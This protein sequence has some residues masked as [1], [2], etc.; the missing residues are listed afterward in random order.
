MIIIYLSFRCPSSQAILQEH[1]G[2]LTLHLLTFHNV[3][4]DILIPLDNKPRVSLPVHELFISVSLDPLHQ[5]TNLL[6]LVLS[7]LHFFFLDLLVDP[8]LVHLYLYNF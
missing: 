8:F 2:V 6:G 7:Q 4:K 1:D 3:S 5:R